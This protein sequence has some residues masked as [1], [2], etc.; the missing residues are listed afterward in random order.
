MA[1][2]SDA[3]MCS[4]QHR[5]HTGLSAGTHPPHSLRETSIPKPLQDRLNAPKLKADTLM[6]P[7]QA[8]PERGQ[9]RCT[10]CAG[11]M[12]RF[13][14]LLP[15]AEASCGPGPTE[16]EGSFPWWPPHFRIPLSE[17]SATPFLSRHASSWRHASSSLRPLLHVDIL[18]LA[19]SSMRQLRLVPDALG[20]PCCACHPAAASAWGRL[21]H[22]TTE[23]AA[24]RA[25]L[26]SVPRIQGVSAHRALL[27]G[28]VL[29]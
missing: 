8:D 10:G 2:T 20:A 1:R 17:P 15:A 25:A 5:H 12:L 21:V 24:R 28:A 3:Q 19:G 13:F 23:N 18:H 11:V 26:G 6:R 14:C 4:P 7:H 9:A 27:E 22:R 16:R 29:Y